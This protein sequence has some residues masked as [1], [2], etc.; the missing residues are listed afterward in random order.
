MSVDFDFTKLRETLES[1]SATINEYTKDAIKKTQEIAHNLLQ[2][3]SEYEKRHK[4]TIAALNDPQKVREFLQA[5]SYDDIRSL[6]EGDEIP[7]A[8]TK[9]IRDAFE[10]GD[11]Q[12]IQKEFL[13]DLSIFEIVPLYEEYFESMKRADF[14][15]EENGQLKFVLR[16]H[17]PK[18]TYL[19]TTKLDKELKKQ[20]K[21]LLEIET[22]QNVI[23][24]PAKAKKQTSVIFGLSKLKGIEIYGDELTTI[25]LL[26]LKAAH[27]LYE[28]GNEFITA[29]MVYRARKGITDARKVYKTTTE[30]TRRS[31]QKMSMIRITI[32]Y[33]EHMKMSYPGIDTSRNKFRRTRALLPIDEIQVIAGGVEVWAFRFLETRNEDPILL[34]QYAKDVKQITTL[35]IEL[36][37]IND[38]VQRANDNDDILINYLLEQ[39]VWMKQPGS[40]RSENI[41][42]DGIYNELYGDKE[43]SRKIRD[44]TRKK[45]QDILYSFKNKGF[46][47]GYE[48]YSKGRKVIGVTIVI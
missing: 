4:A 1:T 22:K 38:T 3:Y 18:D 33:A 29:D 19:N 37:N 46:I 35:P 36:L 11:L 14:V 47:S 25:D 48:E 45:T 34:Y 9:R 23:V 43:L 24:S 15:I 13:E 6:V 21:P 8:Y 30:A 26:N 17:K 39:I 27:D 28:A 7:E 44:N 40:R 31:L 10:S 42:Y 2:Q 5:I 41:A 20:I 16:P 12:R 32:D